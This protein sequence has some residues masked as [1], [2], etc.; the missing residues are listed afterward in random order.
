M[1]YHPVLIHV[2]DANVL[3]RHQGRLQTADRTNVTT[4]WLHYHTGIRI[5]PLSMTQQQNGSIMQTPAVPRL[6]LDRQLGR[7]QRTCTCCASRIS[8]CRTQQAATVKGFEQ[9][10]AR[11]R[12]LQRH[13]PTNGNVRK[14]GLYENLSF[15]PDLMTLAPERSS[16]NSWKG[17]LPNLVSFHI[18]GS[19]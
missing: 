2:D 17:D 16:V 19:R 10:P 18:V 3:H 4:S 7:G 1:C 11:F 5:Y 8:S 9:Y 14:Q 6:C 15:A 13:L 12:G